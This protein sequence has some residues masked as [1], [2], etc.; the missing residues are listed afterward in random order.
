MV[1]FGGADGVASEYPSFGVV[2]L[3]KNQIIDRNLT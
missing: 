3:N 1:I 2:E